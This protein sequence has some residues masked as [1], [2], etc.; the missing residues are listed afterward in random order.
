MTRY[1]IILIV[2]T[3]ATMT[4]KA[5]EIPQKVPFATEKTD[6][7]EAALLSSRPTTPQGLWDFPNENCQ[8][9]LL[10]L[11]ATQSDIYKIIVVYEPDLLPPPGT[12]IGYLTPT[13]S[14]QQWHA[15]LYS[16]IADRSLTSP[17]E[18]AVTF[19]HSATDEEASLIFEKKRYKLHINPSYLLPFMRRVFSV[20]V[21]DPLSKLPYGLHRRAT[22]H[23]LRYL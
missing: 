20:R 14:S 23:R 9:A 12:I 1:I 17:T 6:D 11:S 7:I 21:D 13:A 18:F 4:A 10:P 22:T 5:W 8:V 16:K 15:W 3:I 19:T 2:T